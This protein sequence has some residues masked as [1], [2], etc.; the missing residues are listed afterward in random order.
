M[1]V[2]HRVLLARRTR[3]IHGAYV[4]LTSSRRGYYG[5]CHLM[6]L[7]NGNS[8]GETDKVKDNEVLVILCIVSEKINL[9]CLN[10]IW[11]TMKR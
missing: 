1:C 2:F 10:L 9:S 4:W 8:E 11:W 6:M 3:D 5:G 7:L